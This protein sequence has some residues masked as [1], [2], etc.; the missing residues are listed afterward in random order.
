MAALK[1]RQQT[2]FS[3]ANGNGMQAPPTLASTYSSPAF[4]LATSP[5]NGAAYTVNT[6]SISQA[7]SPDALPF[8]MTPIQ[9]GSRPVDG[10]GK[11]NGPLA[12]SRP[13]RPQQQA[14]AAQSGSDLCKKCVWIHVPS[15]PCRP[16]RTVIDIRMRLDALQMMSK[17]RKDV[18]VSAEKQLLQG[19][20]KE[21]SAG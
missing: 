9:N 7:N 8:P 6:A 17:Q 20:L 10:N 3:S 19:M 13:A 21:L 18:D 5:S 14:R 11:P 16:A 1:A 4:K 12:S 15:E 2:M